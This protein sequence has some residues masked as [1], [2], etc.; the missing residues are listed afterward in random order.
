L[1]NIAERLS[2]YYGDLTGGDDPPECV[3]EMFPV[4]GGSGEVLQALEAA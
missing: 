4:P 1:R 3:A 2:G